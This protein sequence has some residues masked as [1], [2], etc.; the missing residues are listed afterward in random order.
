FMGST[1]DPWTNHRVLHSQLNSNSAPRKLHRP[2]N[3][4]RTHLVLVWLPLLATED[5]HAVTIHTLQRRSVLLDKPEK[6]AASSHARRRC[7]T[8]RNLLQQHPSRKP[9][10]H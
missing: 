9:Q 3:P 5:A 1:D 7:G 8:A 2:N 6:K 10:S 4:T